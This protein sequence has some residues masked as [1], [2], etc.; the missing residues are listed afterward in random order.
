MIEIII[1]I[2]ATDEGSLVELKSES[3]E[4][5]PGEVDTAEQI[6]GAI[7]GLMAKIHGPRIVVKNARRH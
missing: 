6:V 3:P 7:V 2:T 1:K 5:L 4:C